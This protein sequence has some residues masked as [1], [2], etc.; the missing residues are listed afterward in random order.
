ML[1]HGE[2]HV[3]QKQRRGDASTGRGVLPMDHQ[4]LGEGQGQTLLHGLRRSQ[5][6]W[7]LSLGILAAE[8]G[9]TSIC[10]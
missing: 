6:C 2:G 4:D 10:C 8:L 1:T 9:D 7:Y 5:P 3:Q